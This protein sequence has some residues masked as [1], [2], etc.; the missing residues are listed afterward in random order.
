MIAKNRNSPQTNKT[1][2]IKSINSVKYS[3]SAYQNTFKI[4]FDTRICNPFELTHNF[5]FVRFSNLFALLAF[6]MQF[7]F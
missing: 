3:C 2:A 5:Y 4:I 7:I 6:G 1:K